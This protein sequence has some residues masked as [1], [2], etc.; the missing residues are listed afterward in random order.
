MEEKLWRRVLLKSTF[1][2][3]KATIMSAGIFG[4]GGTIRREY[5]RTANECDVQDELAV[6]CSNTGAR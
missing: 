3:S 1:S 2:E 6:S 4:V 5:G